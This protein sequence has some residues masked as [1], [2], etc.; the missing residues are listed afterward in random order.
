LYSAFLVHKDASQGTRDKQNKTKRKQT[1]QTNRTYG[2]NKKGKQTGEA[3]SRIGG[4]GL[5][6]E[7]ELEE[8]C[9]EGLLKYW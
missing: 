2:N 4:K 6:G 3:V 8:M 7:S 9:F 1:K 5:A